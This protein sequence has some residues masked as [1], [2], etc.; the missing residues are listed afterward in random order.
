MQKKVIRLTSEGYKALEQ[1]L[2]Q[3]SGEGREKVK[4]DL[5]VARSYG[6]LSENSEYDEAKNAQAQ[7][8]ARIRDIE[9]ILQNAVIEDGFR[10]RVLNHMLNQ[11]AEYLIVSANEA[12]PENDKISDES[13]VGEALLN[14]NEGDEVVVKLP[15]GAQVK[16]TVLEVIN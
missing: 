10:V 6:D 15:N 9:A 7:I 3:L 8:E 13:P 4:H 16:F 14:R 5:E 12:E 2:V 11:E 1:E